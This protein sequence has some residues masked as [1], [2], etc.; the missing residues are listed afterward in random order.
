M[1]TETYGQIVSGSV[2]TLITGVFLGPEA[3]L[4]IW[5]I[6]G[7]GVLLIGLMAFACYMSLIDV[8]NPSQK[9][10]QKDLAAFRKK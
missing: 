6:I 5:C 1:K 2:L 4:G 9:V 10:W 7:A 8:D 3:V